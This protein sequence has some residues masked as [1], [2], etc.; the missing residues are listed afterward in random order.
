MKFNIYHLIVDLQEV[1]VYKVYTLKKKKTDT[2]L[3]P[4]AIESFNIRWNTKNKK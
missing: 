1:G 3:T 2:Q 4:A